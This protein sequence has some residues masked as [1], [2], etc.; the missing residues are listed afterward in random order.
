M[1]KQFKTDNIVEKLSTQKIKKQ[2]KKNK[3]KT[4]E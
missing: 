2:Q 1:I 3:N 4:A